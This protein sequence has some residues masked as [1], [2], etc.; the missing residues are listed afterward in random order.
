[1]D[2]PDGHKRSRKPMVVA[3]SPRVERITIA[4][5]KKHQRMEFLIPPKENDSAIEIRE[6]IRAALGSPDSKPDKGSLAP[7]KSSSTNPIFNEKTKLWSPN[8]P[9]YNKKDA[10][11]ISRYLMIVII[12]ILTAVF[13]S[14]YKD[15]IITF[16]QSQLAP[17]VQFAK[18]C[19]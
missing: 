5:K 14:C 11:R 9:S 17:L 10:E 1:M 8:A 16:L 12:S 13:I 3:P 2:S 7:P 18:Q 15:E 4:N 6:Q 19:W